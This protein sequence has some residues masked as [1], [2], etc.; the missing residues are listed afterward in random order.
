MDFLELVEKL[1]GETPERLL[2][3]DPGGTCGWA[4]FENGYLI[5]AGQ[6]DGS[7]KP[8]MRLMKRLAPTLIVMENY[9]IYEWKLKQHSMSDV[10]TLQLIGQIKM[11]CDIMKI[12]LHLQTAQK[13]KQ[14]CTDTKLKQ[15]GFYFERYKHANDAIR[16][17]CS[18]M[19]WPPKIKPTLPS[20]TVSTRK[21]PRRN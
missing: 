9:V 3:L 10:P 12:P 20:L 5:K 19:L 6:I 8:I 13:A 15:W 4:Y 18:Y 17:G 16:H 1:N 11:A 2:A 14:F 7:W 21:G